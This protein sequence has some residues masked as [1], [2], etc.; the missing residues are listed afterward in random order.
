MS[1]VS[2]RLNSIDI[3]EEIWLIRSLLLA[4]IEEEGEAFGEDL[5]KDFGWGITFILL[6]LFIYQISNLKLSKYNQYKWN[7]CTILNIE[8]NKEKF[9]TNIKPIITKKREPKYLFIFRLSK[10]ILM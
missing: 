10:M 6:L 5:E 2:I 4:L 7:N 3:K 8:N 9:E 1:S